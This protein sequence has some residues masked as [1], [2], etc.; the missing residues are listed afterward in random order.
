MYPEEHLHSKSPKRPR[1]HQGMTQRK[2][3]KSQ[4]GQTYKVGGGKRIDAHGMAL[5]KALKGHAN[6]S[7]AGAHS[8]GRHK[9]DGSK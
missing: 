1:G 2:K 5:I 7:R 3:A 8:M 9:H 6:S 4:A